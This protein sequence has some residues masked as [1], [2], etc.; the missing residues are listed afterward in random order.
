MVARL[1]GSRND[2]PPFVV[3][4]RPIGN[5]GVGIPHGQSAGLLGPAYEPFHVGADPGAPDYNARDLFDRAQRFLDETADQLLAPLLATADRVS[6][7]E[8]A[9][10]S[11]WC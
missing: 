6:R 9:A 3:L 5:T 4:P 8:L 11:I 7:A 1:R 10:P 2:L